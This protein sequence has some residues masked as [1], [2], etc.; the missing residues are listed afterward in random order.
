MEAAADGPGESVD[1]DLE[2][3]GGWPMHLRASSIALIWLG[4]TLGT[5]SRYLLMSVIPAPQQLPSAIFL[6]NIVG[7]FLLGALIERLA[8][9][10]PDRGAR[11]RIRL[12]AGTGFLGGFST[13]STL[14]MDSVGLLHANRPTAFLAYALGT[15]LLGA[16]ATRL[17]MGAGRLGRRHPVHR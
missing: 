17:G 5:G 12:L 6:I 15:L 2:E 8:I 4:G 16:V 1:P 9:S 3:V 14:A 13:Y 10:G 11:R 7:A